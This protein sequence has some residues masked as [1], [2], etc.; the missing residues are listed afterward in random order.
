VARANLGRGF[1][2]VAAAA[3][4]VDYVLTVSVSTSSA[5]E[6]LGSAFPALHPW[7]VLIGVVVIGLMTLGNLRGLRESGNIFAVP[8][9]LFV[10]SPCSRSASA[11]PSSCSA[12]VRRPR[13]SRHGEMT[14]AAGIVLPRAFSAARSP[15]GHRAIA[16]GVRPSPEPRTRRPD[17]HGH[18]A[19]HPLHRDH[20]RRRFVRPRAHG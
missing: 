6:Q 12:R 10:G 13:S 14:E 1:A 15:D 16:N 20:V 11:V 7:A 3:L 4:L 2:L 8:T 5:V 9:Y 19:G 18:P 17:G